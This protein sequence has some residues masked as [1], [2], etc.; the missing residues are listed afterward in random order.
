[1]RKFVFDIIRS[2]EKKLFGKYLLLTNTVSSGFLMYIGEIIAQTIDSKSK[3]GKDEFKLDKVRRIA[4]IIVRFLITLTYRPHHLVGEN[5]ATLSGRN[6]SRSITSLHIS[7]DGTNSAWKLEVNCDK[8]DFV[9][10]GESFIRSEVYSTISQMHFIY[11]P[12]HRESRLHCSLFLY[13]IL[14][15]QSARQ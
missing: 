8:E 7:V 15:R 9:G 6:Q 3:Q 1:M 12:V 4:L 5:Q 10:S 13:S 2:T 11:F 14:S